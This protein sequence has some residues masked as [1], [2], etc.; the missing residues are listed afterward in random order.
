MSYSPRF[1]LLAPVMSWPNGLY[2]APTALGH[3]VWRELFILV[4]GEVTDESLGSRSINLGRLTSGDIS[5]SF[6]MCRYDGNG[7]KFRASCP[8]YPDPS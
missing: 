1:D 3:G 2:L 4:N 8:R 5:M 7:A 6:L